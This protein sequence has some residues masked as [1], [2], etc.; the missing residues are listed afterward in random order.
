MGLLKP[1]TLDSLSV[2]P[3]PPTSW[4]HWVSTLSLPTSSVR[5]S[6]LGLPELNTVG[7]WLQP[8]ELTA[9]S[10]RG[11]KSKIKVLA[12]VVPGENPLPGCRWWCP[13]YVPTWQRE[14]ERGSELSGLFL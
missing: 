2:L 9:H 12:D 14:R 11:Q 8:Q 6:Q 4:P 5:L 1:Q 10:S 13:C 3:R 7:W